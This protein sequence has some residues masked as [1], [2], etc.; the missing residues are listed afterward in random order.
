MTKRIPLARRQLE[1]LAL[2]LIN[3]EVDPALAGKAILAKII[4]K[5]HRLPITR[6]A[7]PRSTPMKKVDFD[8]IETLL[9]TT[10]MSQMEIAEQLGVNPGRISTIL[11]AQRLAEL[12][13]ETAEEME[14]AGL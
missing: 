10:D 3:G 7:P 12:E 9:D 5:M 14:K 6:R 11:N 4:P 1:V 13:K 2:A 8:E